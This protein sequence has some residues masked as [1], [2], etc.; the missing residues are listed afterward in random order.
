MQ[1]LVASLLLSVVRLHVCLHGVIAVY[2]GQYPQQT[3]NLNI[4]VGRDE[5]TQ[6]KIFKGDVLKLNY[7]LGKGT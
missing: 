1:L 2:V 4:H 6:R 7:V 5:A 3:C